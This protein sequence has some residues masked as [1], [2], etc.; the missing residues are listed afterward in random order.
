MGDKAVLENGRTLKSVP[1]C[2]KNQQMYDKHVDN[3]PH[4]ICF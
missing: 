1:V 3:Y 2:Y 4:K